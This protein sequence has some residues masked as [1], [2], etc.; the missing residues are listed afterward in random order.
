MGIDPLLKAML[1]HASP[2]KEVRVDLS[3]NL[4]DTNLNKLDG[5]L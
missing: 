4:D 5:G 1:R 3:R 2:L